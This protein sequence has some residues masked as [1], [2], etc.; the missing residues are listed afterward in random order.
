[1]KRF[2]CRLL[3][4]ISV[5]AALKIAEASRRPNYGGTLRVDLQM[6]DAT[7]GPDLAPVAPWIFDALVRLNPGGRL[8]PGLAASW[9][10]DPTGSHWSFKLRTGVK[11]HGGAAV[12]AEQAAASLAA[13]VP[14]ARVAASDDAVEFTLESPSNTLPMLLA[15]SPACL[16]KRAPGAA[17]AATGTGAFRLSEWQPGRHAVLLANDDYWDGRA[18]LD[19]IEIQMNRSSR[20][21]LLDLELD[22]ADVVELDPAEARRAEQEN[23]SIWASAPIELL[24]IQF[25]PSRLRPAEGGLRRALSLS[26]DRAVIQKA[27]LQN[28]GETTASLFPSWL[29]G[30]SYLFP[31]RAD[32]AEARK[33]VGD[34]SGAASWKL[35]YNTGDALA[36][37]VAERVAL[38]AREA[39][40]QIQVVALGA[41]SSREAEAT[42]A[43]LVRCR[44]EGPTPQLAAGQAARALGFPAPLNAQAE[45]LYQAESDFLKSGAVIPIA[46]IPELFGLSPHVRNWSP[47]RW[48]A[49][50]LADV[51]LI[52]S[53]P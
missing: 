48:G 41:D 34:R 32:L 37:I 17:E 24:G 39:G 16:V 23:M 40:L 45:D 6:A 33:L 2:V 14:G 51:W 11:W 27:L 31:V 19:R 4:V 43:R 10:H 53:Q 50:D 20:D 22:R 38:N 30:Y 35:G 1:M 44:I 52:P 36:R 46:C 21:A 13:C 3:A 49:L 25:Q 9:D 7:G 8:E 29:S 42:D 12:T 28:F 5:L 26:I 18:Y 15:T 47:A